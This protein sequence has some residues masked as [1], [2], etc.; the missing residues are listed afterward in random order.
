MFQTHAEAK[1]VHML[2]GITRRTLTHGERMLLVEFSIKAGSVFPEHSHPYEQIGY[3]CKGAGRLWIGSKSYELLPG[4][5]KGLDWSL[6]DDYLIGQD[7]SIM[8]SPVL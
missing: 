5:S 3:L 1:P 4:S 2:E 7:I 6:I 8:D